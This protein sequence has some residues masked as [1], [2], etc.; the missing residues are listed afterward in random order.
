[1]A[2]QIIP[3]GSVWFHKSGRCYVVICMANLATTQPDKY[4]KTVVYQ[5]LHSDGSL[6]DVWSRPLSTWS[7][8]MTLIPRNEEAEHEHE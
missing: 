8:S 5:T 3:N 2:H 4:P 1:M 6:G 7:E